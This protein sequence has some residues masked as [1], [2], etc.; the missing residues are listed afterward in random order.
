MAKYFTKE[1][2]DYKEV[3]ETL[4]TQEDVDGVVKDRLERERK[5]F[6]DY[7]DLKEKASK[8]DSIKSDYEDKLDKAGKE[9]ADIEKQ[10]GSAKLETTKVKISNEF[11]LSDELGEFLNGSNEDEIRKQAEKLSKGVK[12]SKVK[13]DKD[14]KPGENEKTD[15]KTVAGK[16]FGKSDD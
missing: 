14:K 6:S 12:P 16:L 9:K 7:D 13:I 11:G 1:G 3:E 10:L 5:K 8:V 2:D 4:H 15:T